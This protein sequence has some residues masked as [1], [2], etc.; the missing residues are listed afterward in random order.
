MRTYVTFFEQ[1]LCLILL[2]PGLVFPLLT[3]Y[4]TTIERTQ[5]TNMVYAPLMQWLVEHL[6]D[7]TIYF[8]WDL[9][10]GHTSNQIRKIFFS[11]FHSYFCRFPINREICENSYP[12]LIISLELSTHSTME[13]SDYSPTCCFNGSIWFFQ[14][15]NLLTYSE[16]FKSTIKKK[17]DNNSCMESENH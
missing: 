10:L 6:T 12:Y 14:R 15:L 16:N 9:S 2:N 13:L 4:V 3:N 8:K 1:T 17:K 7:S 11:S 5:L